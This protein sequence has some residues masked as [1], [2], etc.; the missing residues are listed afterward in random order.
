[1]STLGTGRWPEP[2][3]QRWGRPFNRTAAIAGVLSSL[4]LLGLGS[5]AGLVLG[6]VARRR[7][8][9]GGYRERGLSWALL[10]IR[11]GLIGLALLPLSLPLVAAT[12][13]RA[14]GRGAQQNGVDSRDVAATDDLAR[15][16]STLSTENGPR[17]IPVSPGN[18]RPW[19]LPRSPR[20]QVVGPSRA[21]ADPT[22]V[23]VELG[24]VTAGRAATVYAAVASL[25]GT[26]WYLRYDVSARTDRYDATDIS[27]SG[28]PCT[29]DNGHDLTNW[30]PLATLRTNSGS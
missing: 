17:G 18:G 9:A 12:W 19:F 22:T 10:G 16:L 8:R 29:G 5:L 25:T 20:L 14:H 26:C 3:D 6:L 24:G 15:V 2:G 13:S 27:S 1:M 21:S 4:W 7:I 23:S 28:G 30:Q 11:S